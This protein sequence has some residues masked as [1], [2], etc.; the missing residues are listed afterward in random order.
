M[1]LLWPL[2]DMRRAVKIRVTRWVWSQL[3]LKVVALRL[4]CF[5]SHTINKYLVS[6]LFCATFFTFVPFPSF[7]FGV[8][9][10]DFLV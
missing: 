1:T 7:F 3:K 4:P 2:V 9:K 10:Y 8:G 6:C 5:S